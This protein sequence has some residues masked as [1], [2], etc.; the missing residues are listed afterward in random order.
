L[1]L[2][3]DECEH[4]VWLAQYE[5]CVDVQSAY[6]VTDAAVADAA[7]AAAAVF[8]AVDG[9]CC[10]YCDVSMMMTMTTTTTTTIRRC[11]CQTSIVPWPK[12]AWLRALIML[13]SRDDYIDVGVRN[14][15]DD[16][17]CRQY[18]HLS[19]MVDCLKTKRK[20]NIRFMCIEW[21]V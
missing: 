7:A 3:S 5:H 1:P 20:R 21:C 9:C 17:E 19:S 13:C 6:V 12:M 8:V 14:D 2:S 18:C 4:V 15:D 10:C 16:N 11:V